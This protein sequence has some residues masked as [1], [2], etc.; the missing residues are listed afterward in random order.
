MPHCKCPRLR[1]LAASWKNRGEAPDG[2]H[3]VAQRAPEALADKFPRSDGT[4]ARSQRPG[5]Q[6]PGTELL[7]SDGAGA[8]SRRPGHQRCLATDCR[9]QMVQE[10]LG[11]NA[12]GTRGAWRRIAEIGGHERC[13]VTTTRA[14]EVHSQEFPRSNG[15]GALS[16][17]PGHGTRGARSRQPG[18]GIRC[19]GVRS[20]DQ[21]NRCLAIN[22]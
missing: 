20:H 3:T 19:T 22:C 8:R 11:R 7:R 2:L 5:H 9:D 18:H 13:T 21:G 10:V 12:L 17:Q 16:R 6:L 1:T 15:T 14:P 4:G